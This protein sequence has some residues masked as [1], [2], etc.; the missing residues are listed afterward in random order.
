MCG[1]IGHLRAT[2][3]FPMGRSEKILA[4]EAMLGVAGLLGFSIVLCHCG[5]WW[6]VMYTEQADG[7]YG[8]V[9]AAVWVG[10]EPAVLVSAPGEV[11]AASLKRSRTGS[12]R[13]C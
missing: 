2:P 4:C 3:P 9:H 13:G 12:G 11:R 6:K 7:R 1:S 5:V 10:R 8:L